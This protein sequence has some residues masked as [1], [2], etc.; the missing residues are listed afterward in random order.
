MGLLHVGLILPLRTTGNPGHIL[1]LGMTNKQKGKPC[2]QEHF[3]PLVYHMCSHLI[4]QSKSH[5]EAQI[6][7]AWKYATSFVGRTVTFT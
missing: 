7:V 1:L 5:D 6:Q 4:G 3:R 2:V